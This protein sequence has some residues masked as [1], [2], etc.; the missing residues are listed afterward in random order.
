MDATRSRQQAMRMPG[1]MLAAVLLAAVG[2]LMVYSIRGYIRSSEWVEHTYQVMAAAESLRS[3]TRSIESHAR[4]Y[5]LTGQAPMLAEYLAGLPENRRGIAELI[6]LTA[7]NPVQHRRARALGDRVGRRISTLERLVE[8]QERDG[9]AAAQAAGAG[10]PGFEQMQ[11]INAATDEILA[12][13]HRLLR[14]RQAQA[15]R[16]ASLTTAVVVAGISVPI[17][18]LGVLMWGLAREARRARALESEARANIVRL[19]E[20]IEQ[21]ERLSEQQRL[22]GA[23]AGLLQSCQDRE[24]AMAVTARVIEQLLPHAA[25]R[26]YV[27]RASLNMAET[28]AQFG[29]EVI[30]SE[31]VMVPDDCW[32]LRRGQP[33]RSGGSGGHVHCAHLHPEGTPDS[34]WMLCVPLMAQGTSL[35]L[36]HLNSLHGGGE[37][38][39]ALVEAIAEQLSLSLLN[40]QLREKLR[41]QSLHDPLTGLYNRRYL[42]EHLQRELLRSERRHRPLAV[43]MLD[44]DHF[45]R[46]NDR[47]GHAAGDALLAKVGQTLREMVRN[48]DVAC[49]Y[50]GEEFTLVLP[51]TDREIA[52]RRA[53]EIRAAIGAITVLHAREVLGP[54]TASLG[55]AV[56]PEDARDPASLLQLADAALYRAKHAGRNRVVVHGETAA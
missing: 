29:T 17:M 16:N 21:R 18:L 39:T 50:G 54:V 9:M 10:S 47:H 20:T 30:P 28:L 14:E 12:E 44:V 45:K 22:L 52:V 56:F 33:H 49:R 2:A 51:E 40:L 38:A 43:V 53:E 4:G 15:G 1:F 35:G 24:E 48:E 32:A 31:P 26:C 27:L 25:G 13:E 11:G 46:F 55:L 41:Q 5:R 36:L 7:D 37:E 34:A 6:A 8:L 3:S 42:E 23:Y 19:A